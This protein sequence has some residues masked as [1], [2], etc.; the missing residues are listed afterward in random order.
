[1]QSVLSRIWTR[2]TVSISC[3][4]NHYTMGTSFCKMLM[5][6][7]LAGNKKG[8]AIHKITEAAETASKETAHENKIKTYQNGTDIYSSQ[9]TVSFRVKY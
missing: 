8:N 4:N 3:N 5:N 9:D 1:M 2:V 7:S 6:L